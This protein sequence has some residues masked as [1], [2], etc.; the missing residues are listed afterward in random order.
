MLVIEGHPP[1]TN[2]LKKNKNSLNNKIIIHAI[3]CIV[4]QVLGL[5][6]FV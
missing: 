4:I 5:Q 1:G 2:L 3:F 6:S